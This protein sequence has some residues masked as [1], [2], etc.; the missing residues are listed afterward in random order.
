MRVP[1]QA[2]YDAWLE[3][4]RKTELIYV[5]RNARGE[6]YL[7]Q[8]HFVRDA[9]APM[10]WSDILY[11]DR[12]CEPDPRAD[13]HETAWIIGEHR[14]KSVRLPVYSIE[15]PD[16]GLRFVLRDNY[17]DWKLSV[18]SETPIDDPLFPY[19]FHTTPPIEPGY[20]GD[21]LRSVYFEGFPQDLVLGYQSENPRWWSAELDD[22]ALWTTILLCMKAVGAVEPKRWHTQESRRAYFDAQEAARKRR[23]ARQRRMEGNA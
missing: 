6:P 12:P 22:R 11:D 18:L 9:L 16:R 1:L 10:V 8:L 20:T 5:N 13:C 4:H 17:Y 14:S 21:P 2:W 23:E 19:L 3:D 7:A 15:R